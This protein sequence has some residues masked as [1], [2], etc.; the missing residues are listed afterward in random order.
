[1]YKI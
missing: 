1:V